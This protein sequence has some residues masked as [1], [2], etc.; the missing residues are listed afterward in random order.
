L[1]QCAQRSRLA[2]CQRRAR[3]NIATVLINE[4]AAAAHVNQ[5]SRALRRWGTA[6]P[7][8][9]ELGYVPLAET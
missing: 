1:T 7:D 9:Y 2:A 4:L 5:L 3:F 6:R 8:L